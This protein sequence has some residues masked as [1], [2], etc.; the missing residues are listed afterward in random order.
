[1]LAER[2]GLE[3]L[4]CSTFGAYPGTEGGVSRAAFRWFG[5]A[6]HV[7][8]RL[9]LRFFERWLDD[10]IWRYAPTANGM[11]LRCVMRRPV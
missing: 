3:V 11:W 10:L 1:L 9:R 7:A 2:L 4:E 8:A 5:G 6:F